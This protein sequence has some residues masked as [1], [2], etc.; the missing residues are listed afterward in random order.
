MEFLTLSKILKLL[1]ED[2]I[3]VKKHLGQNFLIDRNS[4]D[5]ILSY[6]D[7]GLEDTVVEIGPGLG[8]LTERLLDAA[9]RV[10]AF[11]ID[12][13]LC[14]FLRE[15][16]GQT[17][18]FHLE[19]RDFLSLPDNWW[20]TIPPGVVVVSNTPYYI[21]SQIAF[22]VI[23]QRRRI[24]E[25]LLTVQKEVGERITAGPGKKNYSAISVLYSIYTESRICYSLSKDVFFPKPG[26]NSVVVK[27]LPLE[28]PKFHIEDENLFIDFLSRIFMLRR[29]KLSNVVNKLFE[30]NKGDFIRAAVKEGI[31]EGTRAEDLSPGQICVIY[32]IVRNLRE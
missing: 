6:A 14:I 30:V 4:R 24:R 10:Y 8:S 18:K 31:E 23:R 20:T 16:F 9:K 12:P 27:V 2:G 25:A 29:K 5:K 17:E 1:H 28:K 21:S 11:E 13:A 7:I 32:S 26:V 15:R 3:E 19:E 22:R